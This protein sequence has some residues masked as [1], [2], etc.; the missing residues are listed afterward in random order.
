[1]KPPATSFRLV[2]NIGSGRERM[3]R[4]LSPAGDVGPTAAVT[5][6]LGDARGRV[7]A[8]YRFRVAGDAE[9]SSG[10]ALTAFVQSEL[11]KWGKLIEQAGIRPE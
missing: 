6:R 7:A 11:V 5:F 2:L 4:I 1:M 10:P 9:P 3:W 8:D